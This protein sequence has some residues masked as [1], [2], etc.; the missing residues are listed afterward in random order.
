MRSAD[1]AISVPIPT[2]SPLDPQVEQFVRAMDADASRF[3]RRETVSIAQ[4]RDIA[5]T[6]RRRW[7]EGG[8]VM[9]NRAEHTVPTRHGDVLIRAHYP[10]VRALPGVFVYL[11][12]GGFVLGSLDTHDRVMREY[13]QRAGIVVIG[14]HYTRAPEAKFPRPMQ[15]C[16][17]VLRWVSA[18]GELLAVDTSQLFVGGD[19]AGAIFSMGASLE[20]RDRGESLLKGIVLNYGSMSSNLCRNSVIQYGGGDYGL[21]L[22][23]MVWFRAMHFTSGADFTDPRIDILRADLRGLPPTWMVVAECDPV[24]DDMIE[25]DRLMREAG[26]EVQKKVYPG[27]A[28]SFLEAVSIS[29]LAVEAFEDTARWLREQSAV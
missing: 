20:M 18:H 15:E 28:H 24:H 1:P 25:L 4:A 9:A 12:G 21:S 27:A 29:D 6:V 5:E 10:Q 2:R 11:H 8:P 26:N 22:L 23:S 3:G 13:A 14:V 17:D 16:A 7:V 19:S